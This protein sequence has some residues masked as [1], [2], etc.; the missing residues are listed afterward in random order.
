MSATETVTVT[1][2]DSSI[3]TIVTESVWSIA[4]SSQYANSCSLDPLTY[5]WF[6]QLYFNNRDDIDA[7]DNNGE[8]WYHRD[9]RH[10]RGRDDHSIPDR[11]CP[12]VRRWWSEDCDCGHAFFDCR[13][14]RVRQQDEQWFWYERRNH[15]GYCC[16]DSWWMCRIIGLDFRVLRHEASQARQQPRPKC[17]KRLNWRRQKPANGLLLGQSQPYLVGRIVDREPCQHIYRWPHETESPLSEWRP[18][19]QRITSGQWRLFASSFTSESMNIQHTW[20]R[21]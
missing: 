3:S 11:I 7:S 15:C 16:W 1:A 2:S 18:R 17:S 19:E 5:D 6:D 8:H 21:S 12:H 10:L 14:R 20:I 4:S 13:P 9:L